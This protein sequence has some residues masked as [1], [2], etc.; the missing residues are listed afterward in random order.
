VGYL[1]PDIVP[2]Q[3]I[4]RGLFIPDNE[5]Y[6]AIVRGALQTLTFAENWD[7]FGALTQQEA[8]DAFV[9]MFDRFCLQKDTCRMIGE[10]IAFAGSESPKINWLVC[11][12]SE[13]LIAT[14]PDLYIVIGDAYGAASADH[15]KLPDFRGRALAGNGAGTGLSPVTVGQKYGEEKHELTVGELAA[16]SH[17]DAGHAH[18]TG[19]SITIAAVVPGEGPVLAPNPIPALTGSASA[20][21]TNTGSG[22]PHNTVGPRVGILYLVVARDG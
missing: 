15:F 13:V 7:K 1:T 14:Y 22:T 18:T 17:T 21:L 12:G 16:H 8:A 4:C 10:I 6:L 2:E 9:D 20:N 19:N 11:D 5:A 3:V